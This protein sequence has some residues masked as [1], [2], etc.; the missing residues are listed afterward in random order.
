MGVRAAEAN[1]IG[2][3]GR[4][5]SVAILVA[6]SELALSFIAGAGPC[7]EEWGRGAAL[8]PWDRQGVALP[9]RCK[10]EGRLPAGW[11]ARQAQNR[12]DTARLYEEADRPRRQP[13]QHREGRPVGL[14][15]TAVGY[16]SAAHGLN[17]RAAR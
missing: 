14:L 12:E 1:F 7:Q 11:K 5:T 8:S 6:R 13:R 2:Q 4:D 16:Q 10:A 15:S 17:A 9:D 3:P